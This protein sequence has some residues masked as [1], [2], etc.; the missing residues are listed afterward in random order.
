M[1]CNGEFRLPCRRSQSAAQLLA[2]H[3]LA[4]SSAQSRSKYCKV[5]LAIEEWSYFANSYHIY[6]RRTS[7]KLSLQRLQ[8]LM[9]IIFRSAVLPN[10]WYSHEGVQR[11]TRQGRI[12]FHMW[13][14]A[15][16]PMDFPLQ[17]HASTHNTQLEMVCGCFTSLFLRV[18][19][20]MST[21]G[22]FSHS[23]LGSCS[24]SSKD[25]FIHA[26]KSLEDFTAKNT[27]PSG[28]RRARH[29]FSNTNAG[30]NFS[31]T[32][33]LT[34]WFSLITHRSSIRISSMSL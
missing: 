22:M 20:A 5:W 24:P 2:V 30:Q 6:H 4:N 1:G 16:M 31:L 10:S 11:F 17:V 23:S 18:I 28:F 9:D 13:F 27:R 19:H 12:C 26:Q 34:S 8:F 32:N 14:W 25:Y 33:N 29:P 15:W 3:P 21:D 7:R